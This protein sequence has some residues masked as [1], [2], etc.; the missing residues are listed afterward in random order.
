ME[1]SQGMLAR[2]SLSLRIPKAGSKSRDVSRDRK[3][4]ERD[5]VEEGRSRGR[6]HGGRCR[7]RPAHASSHQVTV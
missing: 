7:A 3:A 4:A 2:L 1:E 5:T 6:E